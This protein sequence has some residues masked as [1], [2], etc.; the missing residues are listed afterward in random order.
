MGAFIEVL[1]SDFCPK[2]KVVKERVLK[3]AR[4]M[5]AQ[6]RVLDPVRDARRITELRIL[7][8]PA[9]VINGKIKFAGVIPSEGKI[10]KAIE[11][12]LP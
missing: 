12:E 7:T 5:G 4:E 9:V 10:R 8:S 3:V 2:C 11:E 1:E 6:V